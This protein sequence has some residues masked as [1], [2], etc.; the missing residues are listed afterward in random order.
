MFRPHVILDTN[1]FVASGFNARSSSRRITEAI[2]E[3]A[4]LLVWSEATRAESLAVVSKIPPLRDVDIEPLF[5][6]AGHYDGPTEPEAFTDVPD[7]SDRKFAALAAATGAV[8]VSNDSDLLADRECLPLTVH[9]P[10]ELVDWLGLF[11]DAERR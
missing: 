8:L 10:G 11:Q 9:R 3:G 2:E 5:R 7:P 1:V 4:L 6:D